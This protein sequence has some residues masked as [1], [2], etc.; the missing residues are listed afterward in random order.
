MDKEVENINDFMS[1]MRLLYKNKD[2]SFGN[3]FVYVSSEIRK[4]FLLSTKQ[5]KMMI[6]GNLNKIEFCNV[7]GGIY[8][9]RPEQ[10]TETL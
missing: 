4:Q 7:G 10:K 2:K 8:R 3:K 6:A 5:G 1:A 9:A